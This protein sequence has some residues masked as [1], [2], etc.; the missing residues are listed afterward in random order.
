MLEP[1]TLLDGVL[2]DYVGVYGPRRIWIED[3][4]LYYQRGENPRYKLTPMAADKFMIKSLDYFRI[5]FV[6]NDSGEVVKLVGLYDNGR[7]DAHERD[8]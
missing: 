5:E 3:G 2:Q 1:Y 7:T 6:R 8:N 4:E